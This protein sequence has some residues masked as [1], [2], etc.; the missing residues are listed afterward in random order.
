MP[1]ALHD[2]GRG[3]GF[4]FYLLSAKHDCRHGFSCRQ[5]V[6]LFCWSSQKDIRLRPH[7]LVPQRD[8]KSGGNTLFCCISAEAAAC[9]RQDPARD[10][11]LQSK[12]CSRAVR[13]CRPCPFKQPQKTV[14][15]MQLSS[16]LFVSLLLIILG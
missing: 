10:T 14:S 15:M 2:E 3:S 8:Y 12:D 11:V 7:A 4:G 1:R 9:R 13:G 16:G 6:L 5:I